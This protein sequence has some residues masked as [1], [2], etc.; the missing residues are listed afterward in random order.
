MT[1]W[2]FGLSFHLEPSLCK[3]RS[4]SLTNALPARKKK[5]RARAP[6]RINSPRRPRPLGS[7]VPGISARTTALTKPREPLR[8]T[9][10]F[11]RM[12]A[13][14]PV[15]HLAT[16]TSQ[17]LSAEAKVEEELVPGY[18]PE[19]F[20]P[21]EL[22]EVFNSRYQV[23]AKLGCGVGSTAWLCRDLQYIP[24][25]CPLIFCLL[26]N[27]IFLLFNDRDNRYLTLKVCTVNRESAVASQADTEAAISQYINSVGAEHPG[28]H[29]MRAYD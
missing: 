27:N 15:R 14:S 25:P 23:V 13:L 3:T 19:D 22:G 10:P 17:E 2:N 7:L 12:A 11:M 1:T 4:V 29:Y 20:Y 26:S 16:R 24:R 28:I 8:Q 18:R 9:P 6:I 21:V 5:M